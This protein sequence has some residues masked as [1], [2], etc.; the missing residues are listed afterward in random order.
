MPE[1]NKVIKEKIYRGV[2]SRSG[3]TWHD[4]KLVGY[5]VAGEIDGR[6][7]IG[8]SLCHK[9]DRYDFIKGVRHPGH[10][11]RMATN[12][13]IKTAENGRCEV[14]PSLLKKTIH[15]ANRCERYFKE[16]PRPDI[17]EQPVQ[18]DVITRKPRLFIQTRDRQP[19]MEEM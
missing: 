18:D 1:L 8:F 16:L 10:G 14:P 12:R 6:V 13:A 3:K 17:Y 2:K 19:I 5:L 4:K 7:G 11:L 9:N 15:F